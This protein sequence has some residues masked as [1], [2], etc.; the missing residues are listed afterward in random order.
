MAMADTIVIFNVET[1]GMDIR[2]HEIIR[3][4]AA[5]YSISRW[6]VINTFDQKIEF[7]LER[8]DPKSLEINGYDE[9][10]WGIEAVDRH[11]A[12]RAFDDFLAS[13]KNVKKWS[14]AKGKAYFVAQGAGYNAMRFG[15][16]WLS[17]SYKQRGAFLSM[18]FKVLDVMQL[19]QWHLALCGFELENDK[20]ETVCKH[21][22]IDFDPYD[23]LGKAL[24][25]SRLIGKLAGRA[26][27]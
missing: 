4:A 8:A 23:T 21:F 15:H 16:P 22:K 9:D 25:T 2:R 11:K 20:L 26:D 14:E 12:W 18:D 24:A 10:K 1:S 6:K 17:E 7:D 5:A 3:V 27:A 19:M 13:H